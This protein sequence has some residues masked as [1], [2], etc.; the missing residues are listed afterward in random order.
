MQSCLPNH[1]SFRG[2]CEMDWAGH[3]KLVPDTSRVNASPNRAKQ[4]RQ[5]DP[6][7]SRD[8]PF[9]FLPEKANRLAKSLAPLR[10]VANM[11]VKIQLE[12]DRTPWPP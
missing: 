1:C 9:P 8:K 12:G 6:S 3:T 5:E 10:R 7:S 2:L 11:R 4:G